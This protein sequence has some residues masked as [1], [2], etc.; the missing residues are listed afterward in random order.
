MAPH[1]VI[2]N[3]G[4]DGAVDPSHPALSGW[5][6]MHPLRNNAPDTVNAQGNATFVQLMNRLKNKFPSG[7]LPKLEVQA[8]GIEQAG[9]YQFICGY[10]PMTNKISNDATKFRTGVNTLANQG[11]VV[12]VTTDPLNTIFNR[13]RY[14]GH[15]RFKGTDWSKVDAVASW[16][17]FIVHPFPAN[18]RNQTCAVTITKIGAKQFNRVWI[19]EHFPLIEKVPNSPHAVA[20]KA[21]QK[22]DEWGVRRQDLPVIGSGLYRATQK[23]ICPTAEVGRIYKADWVKPWVIDQRVR[24]LEFMKHGRHA[25]F[26]YR[27][28]HQHIVAH[29]HFPQQ[30][31]VGYTNVIGRGSWYA[32]RVQCMLY[33]AHDLG[34]AFDGNSFCTFRVAHEFMPPEAVAP[35]VDEYYSGNEMFDFVYSHLVTPK[36]T[37]GRG[38][39]GVHPGYKEARKVAGPTLLKLDW[40]LSADRDSNA[41]RPPLRTPGISPADVTKRKVSFRE[42]RQKC[43]D[44]F[45]QHFKVQQWGTAPRGYPRAPSSG[46]SLVP[47]NPQNPLGNTNPPTYT[48]NRCV[49]QSFNLRANIFATGA[50]AVRGVRIMIPSQWLE[51]PL[52]YDNEAV[53]H[54][55]RASR[56]QMNHKNFFRFGRMLGETWIVKVNGVQPPADIWTWGDGGNLTRTFDDVEVLVEHIRLDDD[57]LGTAWDTKPLLDFMSKPWDKELYPDGTYNEIV[58]TSQVHHRVWQSGEGD[59]RKVLYAFAN[60]SNTIT[61]VVFL[62]G[63]GLE[64][65]R[66]AAPWR[67]TIHVIAPATIA[68]LSGFAWAGRK[69]PDLVI[70]PRSF[71]AVVVEK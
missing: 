28:D 49:Q 30:T 43:V 16:E 57:E 2:A 45:N 31:T 59:T 15:I 6:E 20:L 33:D 50:S 14:G 19:V 67:R 12:A 8:W 48:Y 26:C 23:Q 11:S 38:G 18:I 51:E 68:P 36:E 63:R 13:G 37:P 53:E 41:N 62:Y 5:L 7:S 17:P 61:R 46:G 27:T 44:H 54:A 65:V 4:L 34:R 58:V 66:Q 32:R 69:E 21:A 9:I 55:V 60:V 10:P 52:D 29:P 35:Y 64:G 1:T 39:W 25:Y 24:I 42:W 71:A 56:L 70:P 47:W 40:M 22:M 3:Y